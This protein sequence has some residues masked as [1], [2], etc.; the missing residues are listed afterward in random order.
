[1]LLNADKRAAYDKLTAYLAR[2]EVQA[3]IQELTARRAVTPGVPPD[4]RLSSGL[5]V[6]APF[7]A[8]L[9]VTQHLLDEFSTELRRPAWTVYVLDLSS[10]M[11]GDRMDRLKHALLGLAGLD[12]SFSG[13]FTRFSPREKVTMPCVPTRSRSTRPIRRRRR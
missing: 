5:L 13:L 1:M 9:D 4:K 12:T 3:R 11:A 8:S 7:P 10:S 6:E 2:P